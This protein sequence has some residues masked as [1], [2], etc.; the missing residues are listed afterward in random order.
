MVL[1]LTLLA[2]IRRYLTL[3]LLTALR[4]RSKLNVDE[5]EAILLI[6]CLIVMW[7][8]DVECIIRVTYQP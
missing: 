8:W 2:Q 7:K 5:C 6:R 4:F 1:H 3:V